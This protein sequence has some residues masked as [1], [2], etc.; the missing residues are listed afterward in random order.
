MNT[1]LQIEGILAYFTHLKCQKRIGDDVGDFKYVFTK[2]IFFLVKITPL[3]RFINLIMQEYD[4]KCLNMYLITFKVF[5]ICLK[6]FALITKVNKGESN[7]PCPSTLEVT[8]TPR[9]EKLS[10][11]REQHCY[12]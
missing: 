8:Y 10:K 12:K 9:V 6:M 2:K 1:G 4:S 7:T 11:A 3:I 5:K